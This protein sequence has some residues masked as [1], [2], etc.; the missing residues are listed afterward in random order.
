MAF[1][2]VVIVL[3]LLYY[4][5]FV[6]SRRWFIILYL[7]YKLFETFSLIAFGLRDIAGDFVSVNLANTLYLISIF[8]HLISVVSFKGK[9][10]KKFTYILGIVTLTS[11]VLFLIF[12]DN[13]VNR[14]VTGSFAVA[15]HFVLGGIFLFLQRESYK[16]PLLLSL[17]FICYA[18]INIA[19]GI[20]ILSLEGPY[21]FYQLGTWDMI[22]ILAG[23]GTILI[24]SFGF[25]LLLK[26]VDDKLIFKQNHITS[27][28]FDES[29][30]SIVLT[31]PLGNIEFVNPK[32]SELTGYS[33]KECKGKNTSILKTKLTPNETYHSLWSTIKSGKTWSGEFINQKKNGDLYY[34]EAVIAPIKNEKGVITNHLAIKI[35]I[36]KRK[37]NEELVKKRNQELSKIN[38]TKDRLFSIIGHD[39]KGPIGNLRQLL[40]FINQEIEKGDKRS[41]QQFLDMSKESAKTSFDLL[42]NLLNWSRSQLNVI[43]P[44]PTEFDIS[45]LINQVSQIFCAI[46]QQK[47]IE[48][49]HNHNS[50]L[51]KAD[52]EMIST[53]IRNLL[54]N[55]IKFTSIYGRVETAIYQN[56]SET[57]L[58]VKDSGVGIEA[59][60]IEKVFDFVDNQSTRGTSGEKGTGLGLALSKD[61]MEKNGGRIWAES[62]AQQGSTF[63]ISLPTNVE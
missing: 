44:E 45:D 11:I 8:L 28:A 20:S 54:S 13:P 18:A 24:S 52:M 4:I 29:P 57:I 63:Y 35:D 46:V 43:K 26:E 58:A 48:L 47:N 51:V 6:S 3:I 22:L 31:D 27:I 5:A 40:E 36:T 62:T 9:H 55:A 25:L 21:Q 19:R 34:E 2:D 37:A 60:R 1:M 49:V 53:V 23:I 41:L 14:V 12:V 50:V 61:F 32:F 56:G 15:L 30:V 38:H 59:E 16:L 39:L 42:E 33:S 17:G 10:N 7:S